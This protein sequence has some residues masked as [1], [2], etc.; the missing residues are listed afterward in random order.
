[1]LIYEQS[2]LRTVIFKMYVGTALDEQTWEGRNFMRTERGTTPAFVEFEVTFWPRTFRL[3]R[4]PSNLFPRG[5][6]TPPGDHPVPGRHNDISSWPIHRTRCFESTV[7]SQDDQPQ[8]ERPNLKTFRPWFKSIISSFEARSVSQDNVWRTYV[9]LGPCRAVLSVFRSRIGYTVF[10][11]DV[12]IEWFSAVLPSTTRISSLRLARTLIVEQRD[13]SDDI[14]R[15][16]SVLV[17]TQYSVNFFLV[18]YCWRPC[19]H[20][21][22][23]PYLIQPRFWNSYSLHRL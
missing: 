12:E 7:S 19:S 21:G 5:Y 17:L 3:G 11:V 13:D 2:V 18:L 1:M 16:P 8:N 22:L 4:Q 14:G 10:Y 20:K 23:S 9:R 6:S 15:Y